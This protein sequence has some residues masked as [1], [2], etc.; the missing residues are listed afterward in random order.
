VYGQSNKPMQIVQNKD[1]LQ[2]VTP[3]Q[4]NAEQNRES[5]HSFVDVVFNLLMLFFSQF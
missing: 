2:L 5:S 1:P 4:P 3:E